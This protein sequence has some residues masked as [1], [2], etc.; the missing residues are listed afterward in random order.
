MILS[1]P[2]AGTLVHGHEV[3]DRRHAHPRH[4]EQLR[5]RLHAVGHVPDVRGELGRLLPA[6]R[7]DRQREPH[8]Q[9][10]HVVHPLRGWVGQQHR[11]SGRH[12]PRTVGHRHARTRRTTCT[13]A[14][15]PMVLGATAAD[16]Y[17]NGPNTFGWNV[18][19][20]PFAPNSTPKKRTAMGRFAHEGAWLAK[21]EAGKPLVWY[22]GCDSR[23]EYIYKYVSNANWDPADASR[24]L[25]AGDKYLDDGKLYVAKFNADG[26]GNWVE[27]SFGVERHHGGEHGLSVRRPG[28]RLHQHAPRRR[29]GRR[30]EDGPPGVGRGRSG[31]RRRL[32]DADQ[33]QR[34][35]A[36]AGRD[37]R[38][39]PAPLQRP[40]HQRNGA[41]RQSER[42][43]H[44][45]AGGRGRPGRDDVRLGHLP[46]RRALDR[47]RGQRQRLRPDGRQRLL[48]PG[49]SVVLARRPT[50]AGSR[51]TTA[52]T[53][54]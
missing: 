16:D 34:D 26:T 8:R 19:I 20:D 49:R 35:A 17:R 50:S 41:A 6:H 24:G 38:R 36:H 37:R 54:T 5:Q 51:P 46:V 10:D 13:A 12:R 23:N 29:R 7:R 9:G 18:E 14:G 3:L 44:S 33:Q 43:H 30:D 2:A 53:R 48:E 32:H 22:M 21:V 4:R 40:A 42:P 11:L 25:A 52:P 39:Q 28:R 15:T 27:L 45:L 1:G 47:G 31:H